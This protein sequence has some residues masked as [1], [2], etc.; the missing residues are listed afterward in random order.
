MVPTV[1]AVARPA[2]LLILRRMDRDRSFVS[3][4][5]L[6]AALFGLWLV[7]SAPQ[8]AVSA[9]SSQPAQPEQK[10]TAAVQKLL[11]DRAAAG[12]GVVQLPAGTYVCGSLFIKSGV[13]LQLDKGTMI[14]G[15]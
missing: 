8:A 10:Q 9:A 4:R 15:S 13:T 6:V 11:D 3:G 2:T 1:P 5:L 12:G 7:A 14:Q